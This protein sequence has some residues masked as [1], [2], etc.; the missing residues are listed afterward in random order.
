MLTMGPLGQIARKVKDIAA[1]RAW[2]GETLGLK[3]LYSFGDLAFFDCAGTRLFLS[4]G[5][6]AD[7]ESIL[8]FRVP[9][10]QA[11]QSELTARGIEFIQAAHMIHRHEDGTEE[12]MAFFKD[13]EGRPLGI[14]AQIKP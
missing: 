7:G 2:Y 9:D 10:I 8:Y 4:Q 12:W 1:A 3:H 6:N 13:N 5:E 14:M 11:A